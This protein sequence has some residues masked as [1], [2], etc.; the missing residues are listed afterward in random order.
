MKTLRIIFIA[1]LMFQGALYA[2]LTMKLS[3]TSISIDETV[4]LIL[5]YEDMGSPSV[6]EVP[7]PDGLT[8][9][10]TSR[11]ESIINFKRELSIRYSVKASRTGSFTI[12]PFQL[13]TDDGVQK[14]PAL[15]LTVTEA[16][17]IQ[18][19][20]DLFV[21][22]E[23]S[24]DTALVRENIELTLTFYSRVNIG[25]MNILDF[26][27]EG[28][29]LSQW[30][31]IRSAN[32]QIGQKVFRTQT[33]IARLTPT[34]SGEYLLDPTFKLDILE[35]N[36][37][38]GMMFRSRTS[39]SVRL[40]LDEPVRLEVTSPP[41]DGRPEEFAGHL[42]NFRLKAT[43]SPRQ[44]NVGDPITLRV[45]LSGT[46]SLQQALPPGMRESDD[47]KV[48]QPKLVTEDLQRD[49]QSGRKIIEQVIIPKHAELNEVPSLE[50]SYYD[51][52]LREY[53]TIQTGAFPITVSGGSLANS[54]TS[55]SSLEGLTGK[56]EIELLGEGLVYLKTSPGKIV[57]FTEL[58]PGWGFAGL[59]TLPFT[60][61]AL[62]IFVRVRKEK[63]S[64]DTVGLR[65]QQAPR[66]LRKHLDQLQKVEQDIHSGIWKTL[67]DYISD[68]LN[69]PAGEKSSNDLLEQLPNTIQEETKQELYGWIK[70]CEQARF[71]GGS[72]KLHREN[73]LKE[74]RSFM[75][76]LDREWG[77]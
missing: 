38:F 17:V 21:T 23:S 72:G 49:G 63:R 39:K 40:K 59:S 8:I 50:F 52:N 55:V 66:R 11:Q 25:N 37:A 1:F 16:N 73:L 77:R 7:M 56:E 33:F 15:D 29:E 45:E 51:T 36:D 48:Y 71:A 4:E 13:K 9:V 10:S 57:N 24:S 62:G 64:D 41:L 19:Q 5:N 3:R 6:P 30:Q 70:R 53:K 74:F 67:S 28:F 46:G 47:F 76:K 18:S 34:Q 58:R 20:D 22:L 61:W 14:I 35:A 65:K 60:L 2:A 43:V 54:T 69:L 27:S 26:P 31:Q 44:V 32:K 75:L 68:R 42:G 12:G